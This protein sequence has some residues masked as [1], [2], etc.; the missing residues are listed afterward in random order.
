[1]AKWFTVEREWTL[2]KVLSRSVSLNALRYRVAA[3][4]ALGGVRYHTG[5]STFGADSTSVF[6]LTPSAARI[7]AARSI[8]IP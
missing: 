5:S 2:I 4:A 6:T 8:E 3:N 7:L 1:M